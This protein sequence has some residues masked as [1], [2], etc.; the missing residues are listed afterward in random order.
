MA[1][2][3]TGGKVKLKAGTFTILT[4][5]I[6]DRDYITLEGAGQGTRIFGDTAVV[7]PFIT[8]NGINR[9][10]CY[11]RNLRFDNTGVAGVGTAIDASKSFTCIYE[12][13]RTSGFFGGIDF[14]GTQTFYN[15]V[16]HVRCSVTGGGF[17]VRFTN[18]A[19]D[20]TVFRTR[21]LCNDGLGGQGIIVDA[22]KIDLYS[23]NSESGVNDLQYGIDVR[24]NGHG[25][26]IFAPYEES[27]DTNIHFAAGIEGLVYFGGHNTDAVV[28]NIKD[29]GAIRPCI[30]GRVQNDPFTTI[31]MAD[32]MGITGSGMPL[33]DTSANT[34]G[35]NNA[36]EL[37]LWYQGISTILNGAS[38][39]AD[40]TAAGEYD[41]TEG[42]NTKYTAAG[43]AG[44][45]AGHRGNTLYSC[46]NAHIELVC[47]VK[48]A[49]AAL[50]DIRAV[51][52]FH[53]STAALAGDDFIGVNHGI[54]LVKRGADTNWFIGHGAG[55]GAA[56]Y[57]DTGV[58][59]PAT[60]TWITLRIR[61]I[62]G[63][64]QYSIDGSA[65]ADV[66]L[67]I[68]GDTTLMGFHIE[69]ESVG[70]VATNTINIS[71]YKFRSDR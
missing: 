57:E 13:I 33:V 4:P 38:V 67:N 19:N 26:S 22:T 25:C 5:I 40:G 35:G 64:F 23:C 49:Y 58:A 8:L 20:N 17:G 55:V 65:W 2:P 11:V 52:G 62:I 28:A 50:A 51:I 6:F 37:V 45:N 68:P 9:S 41:T 69:I 18:G 47:R 29:D 24:S 30:N 34:K 7:T 14:N 36:Q 63:K 32:P 61:S 60:G 59:F 43:A 44:D 3:S 46:R 31:M 12:N 39:T 42:R 27:N 16:R 48:I 66:T 15:E 1:L 71:R 70:A 10:D 54:A 53:T 21:F 56:S